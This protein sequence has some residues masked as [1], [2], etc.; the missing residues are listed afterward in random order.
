MFLLRHG[1]YQTKVAQKAAISVGY[2]VKS[3]VATQVRMWATQ[4]LRE[5]IGKDNVPVA[6]IRSCLNQAE[7]AWR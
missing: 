4:C 1:F 5:F 3:P 7:N 2:R 6:C